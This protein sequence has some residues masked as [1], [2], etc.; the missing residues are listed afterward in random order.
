MNS[1]LSKKYNIF[2]ILSILTILSASIILYTLSKGDITSVNADFA[3]YYRP[4]LEIKESDCS[5]LEC[6]KFFNSFNP[7]SEYFRNW[8]VSPIYSIFFL[9]P[10][11]IFNSNLLFLLQG[12]LI[13]IINITLIKKILTRVYKNK[14]SSTL[15]NLT[16]FI[17]TLHSGFL[18]DS[19]TS[20][21]MSVCF[22][23][24][25]FSIYFYKNKII[26]ETFL[27]IAAA[28]RPNFIF[29]LVSLIIALVIIRPK[30]FKSIIFYLIPPLISYI[31]SYYFFY[32]SNPGSFTANIF[33]TGLR[34]FDQI[35]EYI[36]PSLPIST[37]D[38]LFRWEPS[39]R[40]VFTYL[41]NDYK[42]IYMTI[43]LYVIKVFHFLGFLGPDLIWDHRGLFLQ[44]LPGLFY[45]LLLMI[46]SFIFS[47]F[48]ILNNFFS[49]IYFFSRFELTIIF[50]S[51]L[52]IYLHSLYLGDTRYLIGFNFIFVI[53]FLRFISWINKL[54]LNFKKM[55]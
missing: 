44:R 29:G 15:I 16:V 8:V 6:S 25:L 45:S 2:F 32:S 43:I 10:I 49:K 9:T 52:Y 23:F 48:L 34:N 55:S 54:N 4:I 1:I 19:L 36:L 11:S 20:G 41:L 39:F 42:L 7:S 24:I 21:T 46:P 33:L 26:S 22:L 14:F 30:N 51:I 35:Y 28:I 13:T 5:F 27:I 38:E 53:S 18:K 40:E 17:G 37:A 50:W 31:V 3:L 47:N 12:I